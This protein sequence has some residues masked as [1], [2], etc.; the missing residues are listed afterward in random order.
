MAGVE[1]EPRVC[2]DCRE[3]VSVS[4]NDIFN[5]LDPREELN[6]CPDCGGTNFQ[7]FRSTQPQNP[8]PLIEPTDGEASDCSPLPNRCPKCGSPVTLTDV[9][10]W[11]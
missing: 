9:G 10:I 2:L 6:H 8:R 7:E 11:D 4:V 3:V 5:Q 1:L